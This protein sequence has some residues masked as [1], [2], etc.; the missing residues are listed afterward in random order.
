MDM[1]NIS[2]SANRSG[3]ASVADQIKE[4]KEIVTKFIGKLKKMDL[5]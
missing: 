3:P 4:K 1:L 2:T 5:A